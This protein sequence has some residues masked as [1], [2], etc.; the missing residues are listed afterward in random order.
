MAD[1]LSAAQKE[2]APWS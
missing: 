1:E 2:S